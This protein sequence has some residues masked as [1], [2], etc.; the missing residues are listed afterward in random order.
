MQDKRREQRRFTNAMFD[1][2]FQDNHGQ[3]KSLRARGLNLSKSGMRIESA[4]ELTLGAPVSL[5]AERHNLNGK[6]TVRNCA[7]R[8]TG[9]VIGLEFAEETK[10]T[11]ELPLVDAVDYYE[12]L[13]VSRNAELET[14]HRVYRIMAAR[15]HPDN[16]ETGDTERFLLLNDAYESLS[17]PGKRLAYD[18]SRQGHDNEPMQVF[19]LKEFVDGIEGENNRRLGILCLLYNAHRRDMDHPGLSLLDMERLMW[20]PREY[21]AFA[22]WYLRDKGHVVMGDNSDYVLTSSGVDFVEKNSQK[23]AVFHKLLKG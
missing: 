3:T 22:V 7:R 5:Q 18:A 13:Q 20:F 16:P 8:G 1:V 4:E 23:H 6:A 15:F 12:V 11:V 19:E 17:D 9:F 2:S 10:Q 21:L 14:I